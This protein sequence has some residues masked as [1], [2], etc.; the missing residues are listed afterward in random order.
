MREESVVAK[1]FRVD[2]IGCGGIANR[3]ATILQKLVR[4]EPERPAV[5]HG[6][7]GP[8]SFSNAARSVS[9]GL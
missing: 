5:Q 9:I 4:T 2:L 8:A 6:T 1:V 3:H 7:Y